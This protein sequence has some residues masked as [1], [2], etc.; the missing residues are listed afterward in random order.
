MVPDPLRLESVA[1]ILV[2]LTE[3]PLSTV[4]SIEH[5]ELRANAATLA[6]ICSLLNIPVILATAPLPGNAAKLIPEIAPHLPNAIEI[7]HSTNDSWETT[8]FVEAVSRRA[9]SFGF[10]CCNHKL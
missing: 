9:A 10:P 8:A 1:V 7:S 2:D 5:S 4:R 6:Q 3:G